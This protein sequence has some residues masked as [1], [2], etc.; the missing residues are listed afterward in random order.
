MPGSP[1]CSRSDILGPAPL[2]TIV[3]RLAQLEF[4]PEGQF[5]VFPVFIG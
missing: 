3:R 5:R 1:L 2:I 4:K